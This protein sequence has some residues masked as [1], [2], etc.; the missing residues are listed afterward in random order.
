VTAWYDL[1]TTV[2]SA[3][4]SITLSVTIPP[5]HECPSKKAEIHTST[6]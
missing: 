6:P 1:G 3:P 2:V 4:E 5:Q